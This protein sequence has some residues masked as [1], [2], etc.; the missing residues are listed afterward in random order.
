MALCELNTDLNLHSQDLHKEL[1]EP[2]PLGCR[3]TV[4]CIRYHELTLLI[5]SL[6]LYIRLSLTVVILVLLLVSL[7][8]P[9]LHITWID[10]FMIDLKHYR[11]NQVYVPWIGKRRRQTTI[12][13]QS[14]GIR[15]VIILNGLR[16]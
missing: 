6:P 3:L 5:D 1:V 8:R 13:C 11:C 10:R 9:I 7:P 14:C 2:L 16:N 12:A 4:C 15:H